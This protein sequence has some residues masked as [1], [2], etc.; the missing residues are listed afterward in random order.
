[1]KDQLPYIE[2]WTAQ[3]QD[4]REKGNKQSKPTRVPAFNLEDIPTMSLQL[5]R[6]QTELSGLAELEMEIRVQK[7]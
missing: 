4:P 7:Y 6:I 2:Q 3:A 1:M 5:Y